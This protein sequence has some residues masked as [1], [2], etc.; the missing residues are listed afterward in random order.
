MIAS[1]I[2]LGGLVIVVLL[3]RRFRHRL[4]DAREWARERL[5]SVAGWLIWSPW[6]LG[7]V[8][9]GLVVLIVLGVNLHGTTPAA[10]AAVPTRSAWPAATAEPTRAATTPSQPIPSSSA[11]P[12]NSSGPVSSSAP[13][14]TPA[15]ASVSARA[16]SLS[17]DALGKAWL[18]AFLTRDTPS[19]TAWVTAITPM[20]TPDL[21]ATLRTQDDK[22]GIS[23]PGPWRITKVTTYRAPNPVTNTPVR[24]Q[25]PYIV[26]LS[27]GGKTVEKPFILTAYRG[28]NG[29]QIATAEQPY[30]S[31]G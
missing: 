16:A 19:S 4:A 7:A 17:G 25:L 5:R 30:T 8:V 2:F 15:V 3:L 9:A 27:G 11:T 22:L 28:A 18:S 13:A 20:T 21:V 23:L 29:W 10:P 31:N 24:T 12:T 6:R 1:L 26:T 14:A